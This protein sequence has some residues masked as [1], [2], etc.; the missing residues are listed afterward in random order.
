MEEPCELGCGGLNYCTN[1]NQR[2][3]QLFRSCNAQSDEAARFD[4]ALWQTQGFIQLPG[5][6]LPVRNISQCRSDSWKA[7]ACVLQTRPC[8]PQVHTSH[9]CMEVC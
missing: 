7:V 2:P 3:T 9:I 8:D 1:L 6:S 5:L 4:V